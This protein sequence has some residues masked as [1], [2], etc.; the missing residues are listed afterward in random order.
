MYL[1]DAGVSARPYA[2]GVTRSRIMHPRRLTRV[3]TREYTLAHEIVIDYIC[4]KTPH[5]IY[6]YLKYIS[7]P[8]LDLVGAL[9]TILG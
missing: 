7:Q 5:T 3:H 6:R 2:L 9:K 8:L 4:T 1:S